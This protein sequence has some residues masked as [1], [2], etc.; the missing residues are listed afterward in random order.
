MAAVLAIDVLY[1]LKDHILHHEEIIFHLTNRL[2]GHNELTLFTSVAIFVLIKGIKI[3]DN[4]VTRFLCR[5]SPYAF[6][7]YLI[8][9]NDY[10]R[11]LLWSWI[12]AN[13]P[14]SSLLLLP[15]ILLVATVIFFACVGID[16]IRK[17]LFDAMKVN[18]RANVIYSWVRNGFVAIVGSR[19]NSQS[20]RLPMS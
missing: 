13:A 6:G 14:I 11:D 18:E 16:M 9:D 1:V 8:H 2:I 5:I 10:I 17:K 12:P 20:G 3:K 19:E 4:C 15:H 7:V